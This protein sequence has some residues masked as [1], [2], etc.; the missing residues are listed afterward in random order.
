MMTTKQYLFAPFRLDPANEQLWC[1]DTEVRLR[2]KTFEVLL[3]LV[4]K[5]TQLVTK[6]APLDVVWPQVTVSDSTPGIC[7]A[8]LR[9]ALADD[10]SAPHF[11]ETVHGRGYRFIAQVTSMAASNSAIKAPFLPPSSAPIMVGREAEL[12]QLRGWFTQALEGQRRI[13]FVTGEP[14][15]GKTTFV[16]A[17]LDSIAQER[18]VRIGCGQCIEQ[19]GV[20][21][22]YMPVLEA[23]TRLGQEA[24]NNCVLDVL[25]RLAPTW[26]AQLPSLLSEAERAKLPRGAQPV[27]QQ[28][29]LREMAQSLETLTADS[30][31]VLLFEDLHWSDFSTL[32][33][34]SAIARRTE[35]ARLLIIGTYRPVEMLV[36]AHPLRTVKEELEVHRLCEELRL[37]LLGP[38]NV[39]D[40]LRRRFSSGTGERWLATLA[41]G[42]HERT[43]GNPLFVVNLVDNLVAQGVLD[44]GVAQ[45]TE[46]VPLLDSSHGEV[47]RSILQMIERNVDQLASDEQLVLEAASVAGA[48][49]STAAVAAALEQ[50]LREIESCCKRLSRHER[51]VQA[52]GVTQWPDRTVAEAFHFRHALYRDVLYDRVPASHQIELHRR[53][54]ER[55]ENAYGEQ[56]AEIATELAHHYGRAN[57]SKKAI[58]YLQLAAERACTRSAVFEAERHYTAAFELLHKQLPESPERDRREL[59]LMLSALQMLCAMKGYSAPETIQAIEQAIVVAEKSGNVKQVVNL[60]SGRASTLLITGDLVA[61]DTTLDQVHEL[62]QRH[63][64]QEVGE[65]HRIQIL[66]RYWRG[67]FIGSE[68]HFVAWLASFG[69]PLVCRSRFIND[70]VNALAFASFNAWVLGRPDVARERQAQMIAVANRGSPFEIANAGY[71]ASRLELYLR[72]YERARVLCAAALQLAEKHQLPNAIERSRCGLGAALAYLGQATEGVELIRQVVDAWLENGQ[73][74]AISIWMTYL[75]EAQELTG[76]IED[77]LETYQQ[78]LAVHPDELATRPETIRLYAGLRLKRGQTEMAEAGFRDAIALASDI[79]AKAWE[80]RATMSLARLLAD[81]GRRSEAQGMLAEIYGWFTEGLYTADLKDAKALLDELNKQRIAPYLNGGPPRRGSRHVRLQ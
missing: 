61:A 15:V 38:A 53:I 68:R 63:G 64:V 76:A 13:V 19:Y 20:G 31:L 75:A 28:R 78:A 3:Y 77:A 6:A 47:P 4:E 30:P 62:A 74:H 66:T 72:E 56:A 69:D 12:D 8:E 43:E 50:P 65:V 60:V 71:C 70:A 26:L 44:P 57:Y 36:G 33:L 37:Q 73:R 23:L 51:F 24:D 10:R 46:V 5:S 45:R 52:H 35:P 1:G 25:R 40:Y 18:A 55:E 39:A 29:M 11:I 58:Q 2:R 81:Q 34:I 80:L 67:D 42:I 32:A 16:R 9:K 48:E 21:E 49:F 41:Q 59:E 54:A 14:G 7:V 22:P 17:F 79:G 27:T